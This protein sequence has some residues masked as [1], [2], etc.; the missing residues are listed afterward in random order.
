M[1]YL[2]TMED[3]QTLVMYSGH[4]VGLFPSPTSAPR[5]IITNGMVISSFNKTCNFH[6]ITSFSG[7]AMLKLVHISSCTTL[8]FWAAQINKCCNNVKSMTYRI[9]KHGETITLWKP[10]AQNHHIDLWSIGFI[11]P[12]LL[13]KVSYLVFPY[14]LNLFPNCSLRAM[15]NWFS[16]K[17]IPVRIH[18]Y[19]T[20]A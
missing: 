9:P 15:Q 3:D 16:L 5:L 6:A 7:G 14:T 12:D 11:L 18:I 17:F 1:H 2:S 10:R 8:K 20:W 13:M 4:P 19:E